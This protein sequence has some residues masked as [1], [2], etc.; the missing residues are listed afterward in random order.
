MAQKASM[1]ESKKHPGGTQAPPAEMRKR[2]S[3]LLASM[4]VR[5]ASRLLRVNR[6]PLL[7]IA[8]GVPVREGTILLVQQRLAESEAA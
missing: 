6:D 3:V 2:V 1:G 4:G 8:A 7:A 5:A